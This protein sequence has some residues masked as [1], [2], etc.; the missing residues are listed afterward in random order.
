MGCRGEGRGREEE[1]EEEEKQILGRDGKREEEREERRGVCW[2]VRQ[3]TVKQHQWR[4]GDTNY[5]L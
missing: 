3:D 5:W 1:E 2:G 4:S